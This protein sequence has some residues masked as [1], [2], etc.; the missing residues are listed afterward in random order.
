M[1]L[2]C[3]YDRSRGACCDEPP[4]IACAKL[5][6]VPVRDGGVESPGAPPV[7]GIP[8]PHV[9]PLAEYQ[10]QLL[11]LSSNASSKPYPSCHFVVFDRSS[12]D[13]S[14]SL[15]ASQ[16]C[17]VVMGVVLGFRHL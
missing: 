8:N 16:M 5:A 12:F 14:S 6:T 7:I 4:P 13:S 9:D 10:S 11:L 15:L 3:T 2:G 1:G 17:L